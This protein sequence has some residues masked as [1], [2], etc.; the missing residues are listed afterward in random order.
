MDLRTRQLDD[1]RH[2]GAV[3]VSGWTRTLYRWRSGWEMFYD[4]QWRKCRSDYGNCYYHL[5]G[6]CGE[7]FVRLGQST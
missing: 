4:G 7:V 2:K 5:T 3:W 6:E 1:R